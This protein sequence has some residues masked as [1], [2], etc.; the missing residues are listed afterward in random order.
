MK[1]LPRRAVLAALAWSLAGGAALAQQPPI[2]GREFAELS[3]AVPINTG[4]RI[5]VLEFF[6]Y[7]CPVCYEAQPHIA[8]W[9]MRAGPD[10]ALIRVPAAFTESSESFARTFYTL[11]AMNQIARLHWPIY[12]N[13]HFDGRQLNEEKN[14]VEWVASNGVDKDK[15]TTLWHSPEIEA[16]VASAKKALDTYQVKGVPSFVVDGKYITS[17]KM[18]GSTRE[19]V[20]VVEYLVGR[21]AAERKKQ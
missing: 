15:F 14:I 18:A 6:Y 3:P 11:S 13:H 8:K 16:Q 10:I 9:L 4:D 5:E 7:G 19:M 1:S 2:S 21:A 12:D 20:R 17:A